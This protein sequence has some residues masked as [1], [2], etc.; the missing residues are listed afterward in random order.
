MPDVTLTLTEEA[1][2][3]ISAM[4]GNVHAVGNVYGLESKEY[5][6]VADSLPRAMESILRLG[7]RITRDGE[8]SLYGSSFIAYGVIFFSDGSA[9]CPD[10]WQ[11]FKHGV[12]VGF[13]PRPDCERCEGTGNI[14]PTRDDAG[15]GV[16][17]PGT[18]STHS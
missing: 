15:N 16:A 14:K 13:D 18:W 17:M 5:R 4:I 6:T 3:T 7:G 9:R 1:Q 12:P 11:S 10:C 8:L 2:K